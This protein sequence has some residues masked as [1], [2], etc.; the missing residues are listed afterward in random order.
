[1]VAKGHALPGN[2]TAA[3]AAPAAQAAQ[4]QATKAAPAAQA[5]QAQATRAAPA[6][7][8][9]ASLA[10][11]VSAPVVAALA[12]G[13]AAGQGLLGIQPVAPCMLW[14]PA[15]LLVVVAG[16]PLVSAPGRAA[17][18]TTAK[19]KCCGR[20]MRACQAV[21]TLTEQAVLLQLRCPST[22]M[23]VCILRAQCQFVPTCR[24]RGQTLFWRSW[25]SSATWRRRRWL[26]AALAANIIGLLT[27]R[28]LG[29]KLHSY[30]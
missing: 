9:P 23:Q 6:V 12:A 29:V 18:T 27:L 28:W 22:C 1:M 7:P 26:T 13:L 2:S 25:R 10:T 14:S 20:E 21:C 17:T 4:A 5:A 24:T 15:V 8:V 3:E 30:A 19:H 11:A 16:Y